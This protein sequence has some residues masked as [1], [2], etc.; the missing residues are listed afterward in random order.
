[1]KLPQSIGEIREWQLEATDIPHRYI[2]SGKIY[3][4]SD[5]EDGT[6]ICFG[7]VTYSGFGGKG[8][9]G[10]HNGIAHVYYVVYDITRK[11]E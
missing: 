4:C 6:K 10:R 8:H 9:I 1:M 2:V 7:D 5:Y 3:D 11:E